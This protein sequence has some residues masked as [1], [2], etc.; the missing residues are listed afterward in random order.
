MRWV[1]QRQFVVCWGF[2]F[3]AVGDA[4]FGFDFG[5]VLE[6]KTRDLTFP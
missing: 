1:S 5:F 6:A 3:L 4:F 2:T